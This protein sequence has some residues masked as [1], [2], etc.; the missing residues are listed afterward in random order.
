MCS[1]GTTARREC[2]HP[3]FRGILPKHVQ[4]RIEGAH[5]AVARGV[6]QLVQIVRWIAGDISPKN[7]QTIAA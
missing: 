4:R 1:I 6:P 3:R 2:A 5:V 7:R